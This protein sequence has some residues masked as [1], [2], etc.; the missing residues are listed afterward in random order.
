MGIGWWYATAH[1]AREVLT[2]AGAVPVRAPRV[3]DKR[4]DAETGERRRFRS[5][6]LPAWAVLLR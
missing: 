3:N 1:G 6:I 5:A 2:A 4:I